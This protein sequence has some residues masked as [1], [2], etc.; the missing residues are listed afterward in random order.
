VRVLWSVEAQADLARIFDFN[1]AWSEAWA[2]RVDARLVERGEALAGFPFLGSP[3]D[4]GDMR[5]LSV[6]DI[7]YVIFYRVT[8]DQVIIAHIYSSRE[9]R[10]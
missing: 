1:L 2:M 9:N 3:A 7:R 8:E 4:G 10:A 5:R 6:P